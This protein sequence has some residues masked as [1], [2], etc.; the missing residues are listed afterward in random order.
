MLYLNTVEPTLLKIASALAVIKKFDSFRLVGGTAVALYLGDRK[1]IDIDFFSN[2]NISPV[3][4]VEILQ[5]HFPTTHKIDLNT[6]S[7]TIP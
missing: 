6:D 7:T 5:N 1:S 2:E 4:I 3:K